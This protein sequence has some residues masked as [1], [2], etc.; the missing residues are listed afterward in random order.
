[1]ITRRA[2]RGLIGNVVAKEWGRRARLYVGRRDEKVSPALSEV[3][4]EYGVTFGRFRIVFTATR[5]EWRDGREPR[6]EYKR[7]NT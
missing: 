1:M 3:I 6:V 2:Y 5:L 7:Y 4:T